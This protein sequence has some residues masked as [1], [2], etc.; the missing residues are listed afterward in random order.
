MPPHH[1]KADRRQINAALCTIKTAISNNKFRFME[2][3]KKNMETLARFG[4][5]T[6]NVTDI[7]MELTYKNYLN[8]PSND[9]DIPEDTDSIWEFGYE[10]ESEPIYIKIKIR[11]LDDVIGI[12][13]HVAER[14]LYYHFQ[15]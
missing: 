8:G 6:K 4:F 11:K 12:S 2:E 10:V 9:R 5:V 7:I 3:R 14:P 15:K 13:F 1:P